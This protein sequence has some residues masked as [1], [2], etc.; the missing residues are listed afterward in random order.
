MT[1]LTAIN[2]FLWPQPLSYRYNLRFSR[3][4]DDET[5]GPTVL[6]KRR[7]DSARGKESALWVHLT[8]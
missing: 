4:S 2:S 5:T 3:K 6:S 1:I 7:V 8:T